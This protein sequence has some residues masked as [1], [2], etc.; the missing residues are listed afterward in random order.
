MRT[1]TDWLREY[2]ASHENATNKLLHWICVPPIV[3]S[4]MGLLWSIPVPSA[5]TAVSP[6]LN[7]ATLVAIAAFAYYIALSPKLAVGVALA[8]A[9]LL[10]IVQWLATLAWPL[11]VTSL[12]IFVVAW[13]GQFIGHAIE[14]KRPSFFKD[15][16][17]LLIGPLWLVSALY[18][19]LRLSH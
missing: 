15:L 6:W 3:L 14:G 5:F 17:F 10:W 1:V 19:R 4:V 12:V 18:R 8:F 11:W 16:Q 9:A 7:W 2:G 13:I